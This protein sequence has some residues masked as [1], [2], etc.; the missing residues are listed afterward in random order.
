MN[1]KEEINNEIK[2]LETRIAVLK[3]EHEDII[4]NENPV[5]VGDCFKMLRMIGNVYYKIVK[6]TDK[7]YIICIQVDYNS[8]KKSYFVRNNYVEKC[9]IEEFEK[10]YN[11]TL[12]Y[13]TRNE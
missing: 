9:S 3:Q 12:N 4:K 11:N 6:I 8:I 1:R 2:E 10:E 7:G 13:I 5:Y